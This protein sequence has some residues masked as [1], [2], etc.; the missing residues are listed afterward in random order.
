MKKMKVTERFRRWKLLNRELIRLV[1]M[2]LE[3]VFDKDDEWQ[4]VLMAYQ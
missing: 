3:R 4:L 1:K 2:H